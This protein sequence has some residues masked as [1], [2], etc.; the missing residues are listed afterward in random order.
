MFGGGE[1][2]VQLIY[3]YIFTFP[4]GVHYFARFFE[5]TALPWLHNLI[6]KAFLD[7]L[8]PVPEGIEMKVLVSLLTELTI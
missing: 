2:T 4:L 5:D 1:R 3:R 6:Q 8:A 7:L